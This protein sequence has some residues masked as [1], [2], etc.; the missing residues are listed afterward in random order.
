[1]GTGSVF[2]VEGQQVVLPAW[3][4]S[5]SQRKPYVTWLLDKEHA[6]PFQ[7]RREGRWLREAHGVHEGE[8][9]VVGRS[10]WCL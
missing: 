4:T 8:V 7:V 2:S 5:H 6:D 3:Y 10:L 9:T 1:M